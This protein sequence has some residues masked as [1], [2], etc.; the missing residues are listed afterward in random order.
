MDAVPAHVR[1][2]VGA[3]TCALLATLLLQV[4]VVV[5]LPSCA[6]ACLQSRAETCSSSE[7]S[8][9][10]MESEPSNQI[11]GKRQFQSVNHMFSVMVS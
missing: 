6:A 7:C 9:H 8:F 5:A 2:R 4:E 1:R 10:G 3:H 11:T